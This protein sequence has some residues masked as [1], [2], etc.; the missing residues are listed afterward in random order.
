[1]HVRFRNLRRG[2]IAIRQRT[3]HKVRAK[4]HLISPK[5]NLA[6]ALLFQNRY[7]EAKKLYIELKP[8]KDTVGNSIAKACL[9]DLDALE[10]AG[11]KHKDVAKIRT[12][13]E[14]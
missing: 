10:K 6:P 14:Q 3:R 1:M 4:N 8:L 2:A 11:V 12:L 9:D 13:L 7:E 5:T